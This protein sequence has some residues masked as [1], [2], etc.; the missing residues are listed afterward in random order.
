MIHDRWYLFFSEE[1]GRIYTL[2]ANYTM[3]WIHWFSVS[4]DGLNVLTPHREPPILVP[5][6]GVVGL[7]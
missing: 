4:D 3:A 7:K 6:D 1:S 2:F 5:R